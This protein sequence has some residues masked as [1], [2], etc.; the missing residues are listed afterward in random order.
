MPLTG[1][2]P[3]IG[4]PHF[5]GDV[6]LAICDHCNLLQLRQA[7]DSEIMYEE[8]FYQSSVN[9]TMRNHL[10][11]VVNRILTNYGPSQ[12]SR[13]L[14]IGCN[15]GYLLS[16][17]RAL[18]WET[19]GVDP[20]DILGRYYKNIF[21]SSECTQEPKFVNSI[22]P[23]EALKKEKPGSFDIISSISMFYDVSNIPSFVSE[24][25]RLL[26]EKGLWIVEMNYTLDMAVENGYDMISHEHITYFTVQTFIKMLEVHS[27]H[28]R[29][30]NVEKT[31]INGG[32]IT[33][34][35]SK[36]RPVNSDKINQFIDRENAMQIHSKSFWINYFDN[37]YTHAQE[38]YKYVENELREGRT[39]G[40]Y[41]ASTR[42]NT[43]ILFSK[44]D[45]S[46][47]PFAYEKN[48]KKV[49]RL[50]PGSNIEILDEEKIDYSSVQTLIVMPYSF[51]DEFVKKEVD[52]L[53]SGG[54][55]VTL[56]PDIKEY[57]F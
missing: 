16:I 33:L 3:A 5:C 49:G 24:I 1:R 36:T 45:S 11:G 15:D 39:V 29:L 42:G 10:L 25:D 52:F 50:C 37:M 7:Y 44:L 28:L 31:P 17:V 54:K 46:M 34:Y 56:V 40:I 55:L 43:N 26:S 6:T 32:S 13:W 35:I 4:Q 22:F 47:V 12:P 18:G 38:F 21:S 57:K 23:C 41:G 53:K 51:I 20:S 9:N 2:F 14:D 48:Q 30:I 27:P 19:F 8:Y